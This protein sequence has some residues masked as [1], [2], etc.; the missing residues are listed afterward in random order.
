ME[1]V[2]KNLQLLKKKG[3]EG[4]DLLSRAITEA[5][6]QYTPKAKHFGNTKRFARRHPKKSRSCRRRR[7]S[8]RH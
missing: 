8:R 7:G 1:L 2:K 6:S 5:Q 4:K 3:I